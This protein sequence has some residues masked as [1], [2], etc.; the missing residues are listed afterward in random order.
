MKCVIL[1]IL[2]SNLLFGKDVITE[3]HDDKYLVIK[4]GKLGNE[5][6]VTPLEDGDYKVQQIWNC[7]WG[8]MWSKWRKRCVRTFFGINKK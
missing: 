2:F 6:G 3:P 4:V 8:K 5:T 1:T 7:P